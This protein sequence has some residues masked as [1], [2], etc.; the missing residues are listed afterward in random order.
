MVFVVQY[1]TRKQFV[2]V[3]Q[4]YRV[5]KARVPSG[6][7][8]ID[9]LNLEIKRILRANGDDKGG[10]TIQANYNTLK[11]RILLKDG[12]KVGF[13]IGGGLKDVLGFKDE[14]LEENGAHISA[15]QVNITNTHSVLIGCSLISSSY[16][17]ASTSEVIYSFS[18]EKPPGSLLSIKPNQFFY[19]RMSKREELSNIIMR[20]T[21]QDGR[22]IDL[23]GERTTFNLHIKAM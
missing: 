3:L 17:N 19:V 5:E 8:N 10:E 14:V 4:R 9:D 11:S 2:Q 16:L 12:Y 22:P 6:A 1:H 7:Y 13:K 21:D 23:N 20:V 18:P 15:R